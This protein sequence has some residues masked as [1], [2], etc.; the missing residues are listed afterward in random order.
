[1]TPEFTNA[2]WFKSSASSVTGCVEVAHLPNG[3][4]ALRDSKDVSKAPH[5]FNRR[6]WTAFLAWR[7]Q[8]R[9]RPAGPLA[10]GPSGSRTSQTPG[11]AE[12]PLSRRTKRRESGH[13]QSRS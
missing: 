8:R 6:E 5:V 7:A 4:V 11:V 3:L 13:I 9:V 12:W 1:M 10:T 2:S